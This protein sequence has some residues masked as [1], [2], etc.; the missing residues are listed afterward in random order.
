MKKQWKAILFDID[1]TLYD[2]AQ[3]FFMAYE[4][5]YKDQYQVD[6][7]ALFLRSRVRSDEVYG[8]AMRGEISMPEMYIY[9]FQNAFRDLGIEI[10]DEEALKFQ[11]TYA[12]CQ[13]EIFLTEEM[14]AI[15]DEC[16]EK[17]SLGIITNGP[18]GH[19]WDKVNDLGLCQWISKEHVLISEEVGI[20]K[21]DA[22]IFEMAMERM[23]IEADEACFVGD[24][25]ACDI[26]G[27]VNSGWSTIWFNRR[28][29]K[30]PDHG[31]TPDYEVHSEEELRR[32]LRV[33][34][35]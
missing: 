27:A 18:V 3:P 16:K 28:N 24:S 33:C 29:H 11:D 9:R 35:N 1:D 8:Q 31:V 22:A 13:R 6:L 17:V 7:N 5:L 15:F 21:P 14:K 23:G 26:T 10:T 25:F 2:L 32:L 20:A 4:K 30:M 19:Q 34:L 12:G